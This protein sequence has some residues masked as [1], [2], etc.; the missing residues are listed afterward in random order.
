LVPGKK[1]TIPRQ[2]GN[3]A[4]IHAHSRGNNKHPSRKSACAARFSLNTIRM[5]RVYRGRF[6]PSP[7]GPLHRGSLAAALAS[8]LDARAQD[9]K[10]LIRIE[11]I[12]PPRELPGAA[13]M[14]LAQLARHGMEPDEPVLR[15]STRS[16]AYQAALTELTA[17][18]ATF[19][20]ACT[21]AKRLA[22][23]PDAL[24]LPYP[25]TCRGRQVAPPAATRL[26]VEPGVI[27][28]ADR[29]GGWFSQD[30]Q[31]AV[32]DFVI[33]RTDGL[34]AYQLATVV[35]DGFEQITDVVRGADLLDNTPRQILLQRALGLATPRYL[36]VPLVR[37]E[38]GRKLSKDDG[39]QALGTDTLAE[40][41]RAWHHLG[42]APTAAAGVSAFQRAAIPAWRA[43]WCEAGPAAHARAPGAHAGSAP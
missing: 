8:W 16:A 40:L 25:G 11:D 13:A 35:D 23:D 18:G 1:K 43:R 42:F 34:W 5:M 26:Q 27:G 28:F 9:G 22:Q 32:G 3:T 30:V 38:S 31:Q 15:Q 37:D 6:A 2:L 10:W 12:D 29:A 41:E 14:Q 17:A 19:L 4:I 39:A 24:A 7:T 21:R 36:H 20:C 33:R